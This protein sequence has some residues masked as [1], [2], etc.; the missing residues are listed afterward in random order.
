VIQTA[1]DVGRSKVILRGG[2]G[3]T[4]WS[5]V[6]FGQAQADLSWSIT[7]TTGKGCVLRWSLEPTTTRAMS[8]AIKIEGRATEAGKRRLGVARG[9]GPLVVRTDCAKWSL[10]LIGYVAPKPKA[11]PHPTPATRPSNCHPSY[12]G[13]CLRMGIGDYDC[14]SGSGNGPN[15]IAGPFRVVG[16]DDFDLDRDRDGIGCENG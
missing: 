14:A 6:S 13:V 2:A 8:G 9:D 16:P 1:V 3:S 7:S 10:G 11:T 12:I 15:Y 4:T 5:K